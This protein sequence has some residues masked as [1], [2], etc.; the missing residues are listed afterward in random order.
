MGWL[1]KFA[2]LAGAE[3]VYRLRQAFHLLFQPDQQKSRDHDGKTPLNGF[4]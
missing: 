2:D 1:L 4:S 3:L